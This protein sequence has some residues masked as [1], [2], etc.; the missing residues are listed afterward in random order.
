MAGKAG[1]AGVAGV[2]GTALETPGTA[3][4]AGI[5]AGVVVPLG[6]AVLE[7]AIVVTPCSY[8]PEACK[9][10]GGMTSDFPAPS[11]KSSLIFARVLGP[12]IPKPVVSGL[13]EEI[14]AYLT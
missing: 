1:E 10:P 6:V 12:K 5:V 13:P 3:G 14:M 11:V 4:V 8:N 7:V 9:R 2:A